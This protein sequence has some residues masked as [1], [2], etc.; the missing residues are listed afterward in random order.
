M[1][2][3]R[4]AHRLKKLLFGLG[5]A[6]ASALVMMPGQAI[7]G[8]MPR[9]V[10]ESELGEEFASHCGEAN[11]TSSEDPAASE[12]AAEPT[13]GADSSDPPSA[14]SAASPGAPSAASPGT[15]S[16]PSAA[17]PSSPSATS[18]GAPSSP[19]AASPSR[20][21]S[22]T[23]DPTVSQAETPPAATP[24]ADA[25]PETA[26]P[27]AAPDADA[28]PETADLTISELVSSSQSFEI[29]TAALDAAEMT[30][31]LAE[32]G[33][34]TVFIP[35]DEAFEAL[36]EGALESLLEPENRELLTQV[37]S[38]HVVPGAVTSTDLSDGDEVTTVEGADVTI[39]VSEAGVT[40]NDASVILADVEASNGIIHVVD[41]VIIPP[42]AAA[43]APDSPS[44]PG[45]VPEPD[46]VPS[47]EPD[48][49]APDVT[50]P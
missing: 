23:D 35:T 1:Q 34:Y 37:L 39:G 42:T 21:G 18:P 43:P 2:A 48:P 22:S 15:P 30:D 46:E 27:E 3:V 40:V 9:I 31:V 25:A 7:E 16:S 17:S 47:A 19:S 33:P 44:E 50:E 24:N 10:C 29:L 12:D 4:Y 14:P 6:G 49:T 45:A 38:Y 32:E 13:A 26:P 28:A 11:D 20:P 5:F 41:E 36:P 8:Q